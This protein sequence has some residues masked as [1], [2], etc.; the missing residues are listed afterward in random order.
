VAL[1]P[2]DVADRVRLHGKRILVVEDE[3][4]IAMEIEATLRDGGC[5]VVGPVGDPEQALSLVES[6]CDA[7]LLDANLGGRPVDELAAALTRAGIPFAFIT[8]YGREG[9][10]LPFR[11]AMIVRKPFSREGLLA[12]LARLMQDH[13]D[14]DV[15]QFGLIPRAQP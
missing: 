2:Q 8:G 4:L 14:P 6:G 3:P 1:S 13:N 11:E 12:A 10:P 15:Y 9:V 5:S 7:A